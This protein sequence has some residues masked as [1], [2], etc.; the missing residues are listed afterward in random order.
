MQPVREHN[1]TSNVIIFASF[2]YDQEIY[3]RSRLALPVLV[4]AALLGGSAIASA[5]TERTA[6]AP[7][8][9]AATPNA[10]NSKAMMHHSRHHHARYTRARMDKSRPGGRPISRKPPS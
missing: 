4:A 9:G 1:F 7:T 6:N 3:M 8:E 2:D 5:Q 10:M